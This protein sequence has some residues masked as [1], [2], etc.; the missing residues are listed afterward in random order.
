M[1]KMIL[2]CFTLISAITM[3]ET[4]SVTIRVTIPYSKNPTV[5]EM[6]PEYKFGVCVVS[7]GN[8]NVWTRG[9]KISNNI[10]LT[11]NEGNWVEVKVDDIIPEI[12]KEYQFE[13]IMDYNTQ[14]ASVCILDEK[15][16]KHFYYLPHSNGKMYQFPFACN[17][18]DFTEVKL[19]GGETGTINYIVD[20]LKR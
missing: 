9:L 7:N 5:S 11:Q 1:K 19:T 4:N 3:A 2:A 10:W 13:V 20:Q 6:L 14:M 17:G 15:E 8:L 16:N 18:N 12:D